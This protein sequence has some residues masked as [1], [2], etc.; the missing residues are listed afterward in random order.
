MAVKHQRPTASLALFIVG[1]IA[2]MVPLRLLFLGE[3]AGRD[4]AGFLLVGR[5]W[6][7]GSSLYGDY[8]V[9][10]PPLLIWIM[11]LA[12]SVTTLRLIGLLA[13]VLMVLGVAR[14]NGRC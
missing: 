8:W 5:G 2:V 3:A 7:D 12:G 10:R 6:S 13:C 14:T 11:E 4:E 9:D 1:V